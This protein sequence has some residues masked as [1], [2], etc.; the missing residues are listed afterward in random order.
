MVRQGEEVEYDGV[1]DHTMDNI[2]AGGGYTLT[3]TLDQL[4]NPPPPAI[5]LQVVSTE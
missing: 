2:D 4:Q 1:I 5:G 3:A